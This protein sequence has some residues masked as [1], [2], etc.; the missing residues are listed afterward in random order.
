MVNNA[1]VESIRPLLDVDVAEAKKM[2]DVNVWGPLAMVQAFAPL[3]IEAKGTVVN[4]SSI[5]AVLSLA[6]AGKSSRPELQFTSSL[7]Q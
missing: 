3:L 7:K 2:Y 4:Q 6:W 1:G 5:D